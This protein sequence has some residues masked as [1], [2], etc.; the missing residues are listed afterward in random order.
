[1]TKYI[2]RIDKEIY[3]FKVDLETDYIGTTEHIEKSKY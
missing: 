2:D 3:N 1:M